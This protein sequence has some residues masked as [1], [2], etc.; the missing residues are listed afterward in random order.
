[1]VEAAGSPVD[2]STSSS[3]A[4]ITVASVRKEIESMN[5]PH[6]SGKGLTAAYKLD[7]WA[8]RVIDSDRV[9]QELSGCSRVVYDRLVKRI[10]D[11]SKSLRNVSRES[12]VSWINDIAQEAQESEVAEPVR[13]LQAPS[14]PGR[15]PPPQKHCAAWRNGVCMYPVPP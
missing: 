10:S 6:L 9:R 13:T 1:M 5:M 4:T 14:G 7:G 11:R 12:L 3:A 8:G 2:V 15:N